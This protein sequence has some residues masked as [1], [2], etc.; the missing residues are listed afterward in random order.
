[1]KA[2]WIHVA[3]ME[4]GQEEIPG[5]MHNPRII[6]YSH[7]VDLHVSDDETPWCAIF[8]NW[9]FMK[10]G[11]IGTGKA[12]ARSFLKW[13]IPLKEPV[14]GCVVILK[15]GSSKWKGHVTFW[16]GRNNHGFMKGLG[17]NQSNSVKYAWYKESD[18]LGYRW[19]KNFNG[20][21]IK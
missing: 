21:E 3:Q 7:A 14:V 2:P 4:L 16:K 20:G 18:I 11:I 13:G 10:A 15:R 17:G 8:V 5:D 1:M 9:V 19:P 12:H 6:E